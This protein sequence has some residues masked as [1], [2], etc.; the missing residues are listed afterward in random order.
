LAIDEA[1]E[2]FLR[3]F[4][5]IALLGRFE[6]KPDPR[7][8]LDVARS[9]V[10]FE[11]L[12]SYLARARSE[13]ASERRF[14]HASGVLRRPHLACADADLSDRCEL[15]EDR[16]LPDARELHVLYEGEGRSAVGARHAIEPLL[17]QLAQRLQTNGLLAHVD[18]ASRRD[19]R[20]EL[21]EIGRDVDE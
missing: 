2:I 1:T 11:R 21:V 4:A 13:Q 16:V 14:A 5:F 17:H 10:R 8:G 12:A 9:V 6:Q 7:L 3:R 18:V 15:E 19:V 20:A